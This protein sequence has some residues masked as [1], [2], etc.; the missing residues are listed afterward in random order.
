MK[1]KKHL[2]PQKFQMI[3]FKLINFVKKSMKLKLLLINKHLEIYYQE[4]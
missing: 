1:E 4:K 3:I 2:Q